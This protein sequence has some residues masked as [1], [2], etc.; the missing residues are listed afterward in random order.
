MNFETM[1]QDQILALAKRGAELAAA[2]EAKA[3]KAETKVV[4]KNIGRFKQIS[5]NVTDKGSIHFGG[6]HSAQWGLSLSRDTVYALYQ[7]IGSPEFDAWMD[8]WKH[9]LATKE[10]TVESEAAPKAA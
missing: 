8:K 7:I 6:I 10:T 9:R 4:F 3:K 2:E 5:V 1:T